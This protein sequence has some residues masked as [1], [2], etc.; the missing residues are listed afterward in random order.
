MFIGYIIGWVYQDSQTLASSAVKDN[1]KFKILHVKIFSL[2]QKIKSDSSS[3]YRKSQ[4]FSLQEI[5]LWF[6][7]DKGLQWVNVKQ[8]IFRKI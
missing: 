5:S 8:R 2:K 3:Y 1:N 6:L 7:F 4:I